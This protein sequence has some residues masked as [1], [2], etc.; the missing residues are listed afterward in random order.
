MATGSVYFS[1]GGH[2]WTNRL[3]SRKLRLKSVTIDGEGACASEGVTDFD[4]L[5]AAVGCKGSRDSFVYA[6]DLVELDGRD[7]RRDPSC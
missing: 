4:R 5:R 2:D 7:L 1:R 3:G 6:F